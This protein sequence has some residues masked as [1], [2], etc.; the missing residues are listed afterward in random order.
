MELGRRSGEKDDGGDSQ[1]WPFEEACWECGD[2]GGGAFGDG[3]RKK[4]YLLGRWR[5]GEARA[6]RGLWRSLEAIVQL[7]GNSGVGGARDGVSTALQ[8]VLR[9]QPRGR[10]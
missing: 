6:G 4:L 8:R 3:G 1:L 7:L 5:S 2:R 10:G 9:D